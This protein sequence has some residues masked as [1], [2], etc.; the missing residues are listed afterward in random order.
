MQKFL[1]V[2]WICGRGREGRK[3]GE[4]KLKI[5]GATPL[6]GARYGVDQ[7]RKKTKNFWCSIGGVAVGQGA[8]E[9]E[10]IF[11]GSNPNLDLR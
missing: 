3:K 4:Q 7:P 1:W 8:K 6:G 11:F 2:S 10:E 9:E 5:F